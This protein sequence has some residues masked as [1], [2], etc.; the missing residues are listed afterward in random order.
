[1]PQ[2]AGRSSKEADLYSFQTPPPYEAAAYPRVRTR[3]TLARRLISVRLL[4]AVFLCGAITWLCLLLDRETKLDHVAQHATSSARLTRFEESLQHCASLKTFPQSPNPKS[5]TSNPRWNKERGQEKPVVLRN[6]TFFDGETIASEPMDIKFE[7]GLFTEV[8]TTASKSISSDG[9]V[10][11]DVH[12]RFVTP[13]LVDMH[14]HH[15][16][17]MWPG[18]SATDDTNE[19]NEA[20]GPLTPFVRVLDSTK[21]YDVA[22]EII[23]SGGITSS[24]L[25]PGSANVMGGE[26][27]AIKNVLNSGELGE[28]IVEELLLEHGIPIEERHRY[29]KL[30]CG[31]NPKRVYDHTRM[32]DAWILREQFAKAKELVEKQDEYCE[33]ATLLSTAS[34]EE[35]RRFIEQLGNFPTELKLESTAGMLRGRVAMQNHCYLPEDLETMLRVTGEFGVKVRAFHHAIEAWQVP[36]MLKNYGDNVTIATFA[37]FSLYK[38]EAYAPSLSAGA[39]LAKHGV[40]VAYKSDHTSAE[41]SAKYIMYQA[42]VGHS[43]HL[44]EEQ[45]LQ[46]VTSIPAKAIDLGYRIGY[47]RPGYDADLVVWDAHPLSI[48]ATPLQ[49]YIDGNPQLKHQI[50]QESMGTTFNEAS[51]KIPAPITPKMRTE[52][53]PEAKE[54]FCSKTK[55]KATFVINGITTTFLENHPQMPSTFHDVSGE[56]LTL[57]INKGGIT[58]LNTSKNCASAVTQASAEGEV[59]TLDLSDGHVLPGLTA[60]TSSLGLVEIATEPSTGDGYADFKRDGNDPENLDFAKYGVQ[61]EGKAFARARLGGVTRAISPPVSEA[62]FVNGVSVGILTRRGRTLLDGGIFKSEVA[63]HVTLD[64]GAKASVGTI[65]NA[66]KKLR[67]ILVDGQGKHNETTF[68]EV[69]HGKLPLIIKANNHWDI[70]QIISIK[71]DFPDVNIVIQGGAEAPLV[72]LELAKSQI[73]LILTQ[74]RPAPDEFRHRDAVVGPPLTPSV[75]RLLSEAGV[76]F[77]IAVVSDIMPADYRL[78]DLALEASWAAKYANLGAKETVRL[79]SSNVEDILGLERSKDIVIWEGSPLQFGGTVALS[80]EEG[81]DGEIEVAACWPQEHDEQ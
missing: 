48:G 25:L 46:S 40:P 4:F 72:A 56:N 53:E 35:K 37:E 36:E 62:G 45:A 74:T 41:L 23:M 81:K 65:S 77:A 57:V 76:Y 22:T 28:Y 16:V 15:A 61:L 47:A 63:L 10:E 80:F 39:I 60:I 42:G 69:A 5:R 66:V 54:A 30:A 13:G 21:A 50:V 67:K 3:R 12:G 29:M 17:M 7:K 34:M 1:M 52:L 11:H 31:E 38:W 58:C 55:K 70:Q 68:G 79:V 20:Y 49:V 32:A 33:A 14:S 24:L 43:F 26:G 75:A 18:L 73:P 8:A 64:D 19:V 51:A 59:T 27:T 9:A 44:P 6:A 71:K 2:S 78:H